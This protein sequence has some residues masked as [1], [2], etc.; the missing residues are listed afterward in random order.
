[1]VIVDPS[2]ILNE[3]QGLCPNASVNRYIPILVP[4]K[5]EI[6]LLYN[7]HYPKLAGPR[8]ARRM[9]HTLKQ[10]YS[11]MHL[12]QDVHAY[13]LHCES[14]RIHGQSNTYEPLMKL[15]SPSEGPLDFIVIDILGPLTR[16]NHGNRFII[17]MTDWYTK[18]TEAIPAL[19]ITAPQVATEVVKH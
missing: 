13:A 14:C 6:A 8:G 18:L 19:R 10:L 17:V 16:T 12:S 9:Y 4:G 1:M 3:K 15:F 2:C 5:Q 11:W 7:A